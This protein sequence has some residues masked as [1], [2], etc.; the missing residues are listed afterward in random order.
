MKK[1]KV[2][3]CLNQIGLMPE[4]F[5]EG[6]WRGFMPIQKTNKP[7]ERKQE[8]LEWLAASQPNTK[9]IVKKAGEYCENGMTITC[10]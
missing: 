7:H 9:I 10:I 3:F 8:F 1:L 5:H 4:Y 2:R 6:G